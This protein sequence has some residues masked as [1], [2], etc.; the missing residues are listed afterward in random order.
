M[1]TILNVDSDL[2]IGVIIIALGLV[3]LLWLMNSV[4]L[5]RMKK[6]YKRMMGES[7][8][9]NLEGLIIQLQEQVEA[10]RNE[11]S[12]QKAKVSRLESKQKEMKGYVGVHR[13]NAFADRGSDLSFSV[14]IVDEALNG[15]VM[16]GLHSREE[17]Y[18]YSKPLSGGDSAYPLTPEEKQAIQLAV[19]KG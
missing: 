16:S 4:K 11:N 6:R 19:K 5:S 15:V 8:V 2:L 10:L 14:A 7:G 13:Y 12:E 9:A 18:V 1:G 3:L 17:T